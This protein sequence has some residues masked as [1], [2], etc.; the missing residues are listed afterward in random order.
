MNSSEI[1]KAALVSEKMTSQADKLNSYAFIVDKRANK[2]EVKKAVEDMYG[3]KVQA[4]NTMIVPGKAKSRYT[5]S[6]FISGRSNS[7]KKAIVKLEEG[8]SIDFFSN[9]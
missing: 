4:V 7:Y 2:L 3:V 6:G 1:L 5:R 8:D 9:I